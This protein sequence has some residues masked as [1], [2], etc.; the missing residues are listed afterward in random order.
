MAKENTVETQN[1]MGYMPVTKLL[2]TM[3]L[4]IMAS[5]LIQALYN[6]VDSMYV[7]LLS[8]QA[9][10]ALSL[11][12]SVQNIMIGVGTGTAVG[13]NALV[14][15]SLGAGRRKDADNY[16]MHGVLLAVF[17][18]LIF[19]VFGIFGVRPFFNLYASKVTPETIEYGVKYLRI[20]CIF[21]L[22]Q[23]LHIIFERLLQSTGKTI[24]TLVTQGLGAVINIILDPIMIF[25]YFGFPALGVEGAAYATIISQFVAA[26]LSIIFNHIF[27]E[28]VKMKISE[29]K[30]RL[31]AIGH[32]YAIG[33]PSIIMVAIGSVMNFLFNQI[34]GALTQTAITVFGAYFKL[35]SF[36][37]MPVFGLNNGMIPILSY[38]YGA[39]NRRRMLDTIKSAV[40]MAAIIMVVGLMVFQII[41]H[42]ILNIFVT[43]TSSADFFDIGITAFRIIS[44]CFVF[45]GPCIVVGSVFQAL[46][47]SVFSMFTSIARQLLILVPAAYLL[48]LSGNI[49][50]VWW[51]FPIAEC[52]SCAVSI[53]LYIKI[54]K[55]QIA[56]L[57]EH[58]G[59]DTS[60][61]RSGEGAD[62]ED[63]I[64]SDFS[65]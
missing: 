34:I 16:A 43:E 60:S 64:Y 47:R 49:D 24:Y 59:L 50:L 15:R 10:D 20:I 44:L 45:A 52:V 17:S 28:D 40:I 31:K 1:K 9:F 5:M 63:G 58:G 53:F 25:G 14:A 54:Y 65:D 56:P 32:I 7:N 21:S 55:N 57:P 42:A 22:G 12:F 37:F 30:F 19:F 26:I 51:S 8:T 46:G 11:A 3:S 61:D 29:F 38:N 2:V 36:I 62:P 6:I 48:S 18:F 41:P 33:F 27:N 35:Q 39:K 13:M 4:P 23:Y